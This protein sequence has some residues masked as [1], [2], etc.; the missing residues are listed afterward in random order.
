MHIHLHSRP[1]L[2][3]SF[4]IGDEG[5]YLNSKTK[6]NTV[7]LIVT[8]WQTISWRVI[9]FIFRTFNAGQLL[10]WWKIAERWANGLTNNASQ[11][12]QRCKK[13]VFLRI[14][15][16]GKDNRKKKVNTC[17]PK[18]KI[19]GDLFPCSHEFLYRTFFAVDVIT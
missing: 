13:N 15:G 11:T 7:N 5:H 4:C 17:I 12:E 6:Q 3:R 18:K 14:L 19:K 1:S 8:V 9:A 16:E 2:L 10:I